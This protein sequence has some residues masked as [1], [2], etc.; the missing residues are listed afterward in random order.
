MLRMVGAI[1]GD[2]LTKLADRRTP[3]IT[4]DLCDLSPRRRRASSAPTGRS[5]CV[6]CRR[7]NSAEALYRALPNALLRAIAAY[8]FGEVP[9]A[10]V[11]AALM[12]AAKRPSLALVSI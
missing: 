12:P 2:Y 11:G 8:D 6:R 1:N 5:E 4:V 9:L 7:C 3:T 10:D